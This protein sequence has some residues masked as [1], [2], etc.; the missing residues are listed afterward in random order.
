MASYQQI[1][2]DID[3]DASEDFFGESVS[4][5]A[6]G[7][8]IVVGAAREDPILSGYVRVYKFNSTLQT[9]AQVGLDIIGEAAGD[10]FGSSVSMSG[11]GTTFVVGAPFSGSGYVRVYKFNSTIGTYAQLGMDIDGEAASDKFGQSVSI[12]TDG[13]TFVVGA[14]SNDG[15]NGTSSGHIRV[16]HFNSTINTYAQ[17]G[18]DIDG[19]AADDRFGFSVSMSADGTTIAVGAIE[20]DGSN[21]SSSSRSGHVRVYNYNSTIN[22]YTQV[23]LDIDGE[24][25]GNLF[26]FSVSIS[27][28]GTTFVACSPYNIGV[29]GLTGHVRVYK[30]NSTINTYAQVGSDIDGEAMFDEFGTSV[31]MSGDG[32]TFVVGA[33]SND[34]INGTNSGHVRVYKL[35]STLNAYSQF[36]L[37]LDGETADDGFGKSVSISADGTTFA[38]GAPYNNGVSGIGSGYVRVFK[39]VLSTR[40]PTRQPTKFPTKTPTKQPTKVPTK[41]PMKLPTKVPTKASTKQPNKVP[42]KSPTNTPAPVASPE[43]CGLLGW[44]VFCPRR[45]KCGILRRLLNLGH[46]D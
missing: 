14:I 46:C 11:D 42:T 4:M 29:N 24:T 6:D 19:E 45:G 31:S 36:G 43:N 41:P 40:A 12:S 13:N 2:P 9:Y 16:Y 23:G 5:S 15:I 21:G 22:T 18:L 1:G 26:G 44:N 32:T 17:V 30:F 38:V 39:N 27:E 20:N 8:T 33:P 35:N 28:D 3:G 37:D 34:G 10:S 7:T 25:V